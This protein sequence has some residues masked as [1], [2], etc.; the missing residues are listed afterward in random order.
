MIG[1]LVTGFV[2]E[3]VLAWSVL[4]LCNVTLQNKSAIFSFSPSDRCHF[5]GRGANF[6]NEPH[7]TCIYSLAL[8]TKKARASMTISEARLTS[9]SAW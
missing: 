8:K 1:V 6:R 3:P 9:F 5:G 2:A 4:R 7:R